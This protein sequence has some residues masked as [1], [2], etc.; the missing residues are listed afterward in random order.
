[1]GNLA[2]GFDD[3]TGKG[4]QFDLKVTGFD[5]CAANVGIYTSVGNQ[6]PQKIANYG[7]RQTEQQ[8]TNKGKQ[9]GHDTKVQRTY[10]ILSVM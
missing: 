2:I 7:P 4:E 10:A 9:Q 8:K 5:T 1:M 6:T 3:Q